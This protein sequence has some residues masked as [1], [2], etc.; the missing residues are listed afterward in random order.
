[1][2][3]MKHMSD[4]HGTRGALARACLCLALLLPF[5]PHEARAEDTTANRV[6]AAVM[7]NFAKFVAWPEQAGDEQS[8][9]VIGVCGASRLEPHLR[10]F[11]SHSVQGRMLE[12]RTF[13]PAGPI[14]DCRI[15]F[16]GADVP[17]DD[18]RDSLADRPVLTI[19]DRPGFLD[20]GGMVLLYL[21]DDRKIRFDVNEDAAH[22][23][24]M[25]ISSKLLRLER[26][27][28]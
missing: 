24:G 8:T 1:M 25:I 21:S 27:R 2:E 3:T 22:D 10:A 18:L 4:R 7:F 13:D 6:K 17:L 19:S 16:L 12:V 28:E 14:P 26:P 23:A 20:D 11:T 9:F 15:V 5:L